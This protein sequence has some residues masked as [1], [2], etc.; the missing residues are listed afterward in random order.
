MSYFDVLHDIK[1][2]A[3]ADL[4]KEFGVDFMDDIQDYCT[5]LQENF[6]L[7]C[8]PMVILMFMGLSAADP[9]EIPYMFQANLFSAFCMGAIMEKYPEFF[10]LLVKPED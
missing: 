3:L 4:R 7:S 8:S 10:D 9:E 5:G 2:E 1:P 6:D